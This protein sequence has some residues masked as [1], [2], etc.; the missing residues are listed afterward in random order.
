MAYPC[1]NR[2][3]LHISLPLTP[4]RHRAL[5]I[6]E[7]R[8]KCNRQQHLRR[9]AHRLNTR[10]PDSIAPTVPPRRSRTLNQTPPAVTSRIM[11]SA[12]FF[13]NRLIIGPRLSESGCQSSPK[14][15]KVLSRSCRKCPFVLDPLFGQRIGLSLQCSS[16]PRPHGSL[17]PFRESA[18]TMAL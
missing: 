9:S 13:L 2:R 1:L 11:C 5:S 3:R 8:T 4:C 10:N 14:F 17:G 15:P 6:V 16:S 18:S 12:I 7:V